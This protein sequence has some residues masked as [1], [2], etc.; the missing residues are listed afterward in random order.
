MPKTRLKRNRARLPDPI[1]ILTRPDVHILADY[2]NDLV[3]TLRLR[4]EGNEAEL[5]FQD[6]RSR[7]LLIED[8]T[9]LDFGSFVVL[10]DAASGPITVTLPFARDSFN[11]QGVYI[12]RET[13]GSN[14]VVLETQP[15]ELIENAASVNVPAGEGVTFTSDGDNWWLV[16]NYN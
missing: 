6:T 4:L 10:A 14:V 8:D 7:P 1:R 11:T 3:K 12:V 2:I 9:G 15:G 16:S 5:D 13:S